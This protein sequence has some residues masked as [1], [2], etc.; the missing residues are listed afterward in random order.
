MRDGAT[1]DF[2]TGRTFDPVLMDGVFDESL[3]ESVYINSTRS[4]LVKKNPE[5]LLMQIIRRHISDINDI[6]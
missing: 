5:R 1:D 3:S 4:L 6:L 2:L